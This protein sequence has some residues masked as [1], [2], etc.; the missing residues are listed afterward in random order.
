MGSWAFQTDTRE[1]KD[2]STPEQGASTV[3]FITDILQ[4][5]QWEGVVEKVAC[6][7]AH[8]LSKLGSLCS[9]PLTGMGKG[10]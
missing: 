2:F 6:E 3:V 10:I 1:Q 7:E 8:A 5:R 4:K 9:A